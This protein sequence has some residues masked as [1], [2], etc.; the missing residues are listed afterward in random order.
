MSQDNRETWLN[1]VADCM[2]PWFADL[3]CPLPAYRVAIGFPSTGKRGSRIGECWD[4]SCSEDGRFEILIRPDQD[5]A[6]MVAGILA[7]ELVHAAVGIEAGHGPKFRKVAKAIGLEGQMRS[8]VPGPAMVAQIN[9]II[10]LVGP[11]PHARLA[12]DGETS[13]PKKQTTRMMKCV[14]SE[15]GY[16]VRI[17]RKWLDEVGTPHCP[18]H[19]Q[20]QVEITGD[21]LTDDDKVP[22]GCSGP[23]T[24]HQPPEQIDIEELIAAA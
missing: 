5:D 10:D 3:G 21:D 12:F 9:R 11:L 23:T 16:T 7:H 13:G 15:C 20:M 14:C 8:T 2:G 4:G 18:A 22:E 24:R 1:A 6:I 17:A 19:G